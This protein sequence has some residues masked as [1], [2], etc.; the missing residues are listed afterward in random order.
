MHAVIIVSD[1]M[2]DAVNLKIV[3]GK[4]QVI[5]RCCACIKTVLLTM[6]KTYKIFAR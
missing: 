5:E 6:R 1:R 3:N 4:I 2:E